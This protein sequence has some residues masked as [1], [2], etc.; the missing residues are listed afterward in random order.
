MTTRKLLAQQHYAFRTVRLTAL[1]SCCRLIPAPEQHPP[2]SR[3]GRTRQGTFIT[4]CNRSRRAASFCRPSCNG[5]AL[6]G[7]T[8]PA[9]PPRPDARRT[10]PGGRTGRGRRFEFNGICAHFTACVR[11]PRACVRQPENFFHGSP[12]VAQGWMTAWTVCQTPGPG[13]SLARAPGPWSMDRQGRPGT[14]EERAVAGRPTPAGAA[15]SDVANCRV[16]RVP[17]RPKERLWWRV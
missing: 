14:C 6:D 5:A 10:H 13:M 8:P 1:P 3:W 17:N 12:L 9:I 4:G 15:A 2:T 16:F 11:R 7:V